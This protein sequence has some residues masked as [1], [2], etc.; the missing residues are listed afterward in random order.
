M[1]LIILY[2]IENY[3]IEYN[4]VICILYNY[5]IIIFVQTL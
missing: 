5:N 2:T 4:K 3:V 1:G